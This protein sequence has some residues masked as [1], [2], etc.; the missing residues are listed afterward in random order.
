MRTLSFAVPLTAAL[1]AGTWLA[2][3]ARADIT[4]APIGRWSQGIAFSQDGKTIPVQNMVERT[5]QVF[6]WN[7][8]Q[9]QPG[10]VIPVGAGPAAVQ[11]AW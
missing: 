10:A 5:I 3:A 2:G 7:E 8:T 9:L 6:R 11:T 1:M 4:E